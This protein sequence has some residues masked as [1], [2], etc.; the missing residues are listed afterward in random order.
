MLLPNR[1]HARVDRAK[2][3]DYLLS[4]SHP[5]GYGKAVFFMRLGFRL[6][7]WEML[8]GAPR[9]ERRG[10]VRGVP[11][12]CRRGGLQV[13]GRQ[14]LQSRSGLAEVVRNGREGTV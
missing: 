11:R 14:A 7:E 2:I 4:T 5:D 6:A 8:A 9:E 3:T 13:R 1:E 10:G 12:R